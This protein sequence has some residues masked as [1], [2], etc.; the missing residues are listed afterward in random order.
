ME[1]LTELTEHVDKFI[2]MVTFT[3]EGTG[4]S[5]ATSWSG[6]VLAEPFKVSV[7][8]ADS[9]VLGLPFIGEISV[10]RHDGTPMPDEPIEVCLSQFKVT[11]GFQGTRPNAY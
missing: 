5:A 3:E 1:S 10:S 9:T 4:K 11:C 6:S 7:T 8:G 2:V